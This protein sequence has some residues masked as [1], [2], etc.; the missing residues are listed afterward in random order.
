[1]FL[2]GYGSVP[3]S[4]RALRNLTP[5]AS[6]RWAAMGFSQGGGA[7][8]AATSLAGS[9][10]D[11]LELVGSVSVTPSV[12]TSPLAGLAAKE[13]LS[14]YQ[15]VV[16][17]WTLIG[18]DRSDPAFAIGKYWHGA[19]FADRADVA[20]CSYSGAD[21]GARERVLRTMSSGDLALAPD[22]A[23]ALAARLEKL[24]VPGGGVT[25][26]MYVVYAGR[27]VYIDPSWTRHAIDRECNSGATIL[28]KYDADAGH[29]SVDGSGAASWLAERFAG[30]AAPSSCGKPSR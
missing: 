28:V 3:D 11:G 24:S 21:A 17:L 2:T 26:P 18:L 19:S 16:Y 10:G 20:G 8:W 5:T 6:K 30:R 9:Y 29:D 23:G 27:D 14:S 12:D 22:E 4:V 25:A 13:L 7:S 1:M 15:L